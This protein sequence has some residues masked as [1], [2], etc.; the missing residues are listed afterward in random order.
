MTDYGRGSGSEPWHPDDPLFGDAYDRGQGYPQQQPPPQD[1]EWQDPY[2]TGQHQQHQQY[3]QQ[4]G[5][6][7]PQQPQ[8]D[9][10]QQEYPQQ[11]YPQ[12]EYPQQG[13]PQ[14]QQQYPMQQPQQY[15]TGQHPHQQPQQQYPQ[16][17]GYGYDT[18]SHGTY[19]SGSHATGGYPAQDPYGGPQPDYYGQGGG[20]QQQP[21][22]QYQPGPGM[23]PPQHPQQ[24]GPGM[25]PPQHPQQPQQPQ[26]PQAGQPGQARLQQPGPGGRPQE[27]G[28]RPLRTAPGNTGEWNPE[29]D[30]D[31]REHAFFADRDDPDDH[32]DTP[33]GNEAGGRRAGRSQPKGGKKR[34]SG[35]ACLTVLV[36]LGGGLAGGVYYGY[37]VYQSHFGPAPD[38]SGN[39]TG[40]V[41]VE[42]P[43][44]ATLTTI[45]NVL[46]KAGV[47]KSVDAFTAAARKNPKGQTIQA[48]YYQ[49]NKNM[50]AAAAVTMMLDPKSQNA[51]IIPEGWRATRI[52]AAI[53]TKLGLKTGTTAAQVKGVDLGL[54]AWAKG[55]LEGFLFPAKYG[56]GK[57]MKPVDVVKSMVNQAKAEYTADGI[58]TAASKVGKTPLEIIEIASLIQAEA[59]EPEDFGKVSR[60]IYNRLDQDM[61]LQFDST[62]NYAMGRSTLNTSNKDISYKSPYNTYDHN[63][64]PPGP[65]DS[66]GHDAIEAALNPTSGNWLYFVTVK[67]GD[68]RFTASYS[69]HQ[70][71]V[72]DFNDYQK[73]HGG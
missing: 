10:P 43:K 59:Q 8:Q 51:M 34:R 57:G 24:P 30:S 35:C 48:G 31:P 45:G 52:Y 73:K 39:G 11:E 36:V 60:V 54:P 29:E 20:Y 69:T 4:G 55:N 53:D 67:P 46:K 61:K 72:Q 37:G 1:G 6:Q 66:P 19:D 15:D 18:G 62:I 63:G 26:G 28:A 49:L 2:A 56:A 68:T 40:S 12:Q 64:L 23:Q 21:Q 9:Y 47:V 17:G 44:G 25:Q 42:V 41:Q 50:S 22:Q 70:K 38:Y 27:P 58:E 14:H 16:Q 33:T 3:P 5:G 7:Y 71:N 65:I 13:Y 32:D